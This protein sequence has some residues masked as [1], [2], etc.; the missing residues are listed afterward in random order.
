MFNMER[1]RPTTSE[2]MTFDNVDDDGQTTEGRMP[3]ACIYDKL[4][5]EPT[6]R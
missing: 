1:I 4:S 3:D 6:V 2:E 5:Y